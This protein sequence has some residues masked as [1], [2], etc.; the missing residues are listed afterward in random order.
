[1]S[2]LPPSRVLPHRRL[3]IAV[4]SRVSGYSLAA[5]TVR[6]TQRRASVFMCGRL[7]HFSPPGAIKLASRLGGCLPQFNNDKQVE[8]VWWGVG[9]GEQSHKIE[10][11]FDPRYTM[12]P[13]K[14]PSTLKDVMYILYIDNV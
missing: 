8:M 11:F 1:V 2:F 6:R 4:P 13:K 14:K 9:G 5:P 3:T 12:K 7:E 10:I